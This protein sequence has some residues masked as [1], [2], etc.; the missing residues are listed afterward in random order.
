[1]LFRR[2]VTSDIGPPIKIVAPLLIVQSIWQSSINTFPNTTS[3]AL[4]CV[5]SYWFFMQY[6]VVSL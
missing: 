3:T 4:I 1:M 2:I 6:L 5:A